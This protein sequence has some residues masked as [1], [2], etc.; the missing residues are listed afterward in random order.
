METHLLEVATGTVKTPDGEQHQVHGGAYLTPEAFL[1][2]QAELE[3]LRQAQA[4]A[5]ASRLLPTLVIGAGV[6]GLAL[7]LWLGRR[8]GDES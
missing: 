2:T 8:S 6:F 7:G 4:D 1:H 3:K 5:A